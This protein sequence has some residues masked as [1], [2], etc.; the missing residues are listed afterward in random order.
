MSV[1]LRHPLAE[2]GFLPIQVS[3]SLPQQLVC[4]VGVELLDRL[5]VS[6]AIRPQ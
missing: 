4:W 2:L 5:H 1:I 6:L 3:N